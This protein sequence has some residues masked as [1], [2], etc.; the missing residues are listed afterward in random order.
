MWVLR[1]LLKLI[2]LHISYAWWYSTCTFPFASLTQ[3]APAI[4]Y[5]D[6]AIC[7]SDHQL[8]TNQ[9]FQ[10]HNAFIHSLHINNPINP[11]VWNKKPNPCI[12]VFT[13]LP[14][15]F[16]PWH[17]LTHHSS[18]LFYHLVSCTWHT[19]IFLVHNVSATS[20]DLPDIIPMFQVANLIQSGTLKVFFCPLP[21]HTGFPA[22]HQVYD[23]HNDRNSWPVLN[24]HCTVFCCNVD[25]CTVF[26]K[27]FYLTTL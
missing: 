10:A 9:H 6:F 13:T 25:W 27:F 23:L 3:F 17:A 22:G 16:I 5:L 21:T 14:E 19:L 8:V 12:T 4:S 18:T 11:P 24:L 7:Y 26:L 2:I 20:A 1:S 15:E